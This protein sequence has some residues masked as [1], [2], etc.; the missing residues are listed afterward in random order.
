M[1]CKICIY[2]NN[3]SLQDIAKD[4]TGCEGHSKEKVPKEGQ[5]KCNTCH[6]WIDKDRAFKLKYIDEYC[7]FRCY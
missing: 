4:I 6:E 7:C 3:C 1:N 2:D 5:V